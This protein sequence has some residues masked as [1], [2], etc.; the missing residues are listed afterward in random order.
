[1]F[2]PGFDSPILLLLRVSDSTVFCVQMRKA[3][4]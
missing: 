4:N 2:V 3:Y 1:M